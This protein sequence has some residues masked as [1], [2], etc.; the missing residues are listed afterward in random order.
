MT[1]PPATTPVAPAP[2]VA[3][4]PSPVPSAPVV[5]VGAGPVGLLLACELRTAGVPV[6]VVE[7]L[8]EPMT[9]SRASQL[10]ALTAELLHE[11]GFDA[12]LAEAAHEPRAHFGGLGYDLSALDSPYAGN[13]KVPQYRTEAFLGQRATELGATVLRST[14]LTGLTEGPDHVLCEVHGPAGPRRI[15]ARYVVGCDGARGA[16]RRLAGFAVTATAPTRELLR[17]DV[18]GLAVRDRRFERLPGGF[19]VASTRDGVTRVMVHATGR[20]VTARTGPP[21]FAEIAARWERVTGEDISGGRAVWLDAFDNSTAH[22]TAYRRG[23][24]LL[25]G[26]AAHHHLPIGGQ[27]LNTG[28]QDAV[29]L[30]WKLAATARGLAAP[31]LLDT[32]HDERHPVAARVL[33]HVTAQELLLLGGSGAE[34]LRA[35]LTELTGLDRVRTHLAAAASNL[36]DRYGPPG[37]GLTG[38]RV[39][40]LR[41]RT[42]TGPLLATGPGP[43][44]LT[45]APGAAGPGRFPVP[46]LRVIDESGSLPGITTVLLRPDGYVAWAD[47]SEEDLDQA[48]GKLLHPEVR[49]RNARL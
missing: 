6:V 13:W 16:V 20:A 19:A 18:T 26:D 41:L 47:G 1:R 49:K 29:N 36:G 12:L 40:G 23:R 34:P 2:S 25:A 39:A 7:R 9:E 28:L 11:R 35:V 17:A 8:A 43:V 30:G 10:T 15:E 32:Y 22:A 46:V 44:L 3:T 24:V 42:A 21:E 48:L 27:A 5:V 37:P 31:G 33:A 45:L 38:R 14:E 4:A